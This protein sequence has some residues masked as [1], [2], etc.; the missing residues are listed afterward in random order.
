[1]L[2]ALC[3]SLFS[4]IL[5]F[6]LMAVST[7]QFLSAQDQEITQTEDRIQ[8]M[9]EKRRSFNKKNNKGFLIQLYNGKEKTAKRIKMNFEKAFPDIPTRLEYIQP[10]WKIQV[11]KFANKLEADRSLNKIRKKFAG[12]IV[13]PM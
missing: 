11:G 9:L 6:F 8:K 5:F 3:C 13:I 4:R 2:S 7:F 10:E 12:A 1:M